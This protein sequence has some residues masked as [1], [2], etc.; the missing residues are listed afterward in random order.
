VPYECCDVIS[1]I[2]TVR[3][4]LNED[5]ELVSVIQRWLFRT[6]LFRIKLTPVHPIIASEPPSESL[7]LKCA[8]IRVN[9]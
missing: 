6:K 5:S 8:A 9:V 1:W 2:G 7:G 3:S 4:F